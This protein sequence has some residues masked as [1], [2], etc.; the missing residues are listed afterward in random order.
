MYKSNIHHKKTRGQRNEKKRDLIYPEEGQEFGFVQDMLGN[1][2][3]NVICEDG[4]KRVGRIRG[5]MRKFKHKVIINTGDIILVSVRE[6]ENDKVDVIYKYSYEE[7]NYLSYHGELPE[8]INKV[9]QQKDNQTFQTHADDSYIVFAEE[10]PGGGDKPLSPPTKE[11]SEESLDI[12][13]I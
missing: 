9:Y 2:R 13:E 8:K 7:A 5:S 12:D 6:Y 10:A 3:V 4:T 11:E 1:G